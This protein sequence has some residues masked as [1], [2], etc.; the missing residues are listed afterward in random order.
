MF[1]A[2]FTYVSLCLDSISSTALK[3]A[4]K[5]QPNPA[6]TAANQINP[7]AMDESCSQYLLMEG[8]PVITIA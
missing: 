3:T 7:L 6:L 8:H 2:S 4:P 5:A 1:K